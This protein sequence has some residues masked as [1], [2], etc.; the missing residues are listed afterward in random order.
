M[1]NKLGLFLLRFICAI[2]C[3]ILP[4]FH[5]LADTIEENRPI[6]SYFID[7]I[8]LRLI[9]QGGYYSLAIIFVLTIISMLNK[10]FREIILSIVLAIFGIMLTVFIY[11]AY[12]DFKFIPD[13]Y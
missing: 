12:L 8:V 11:E 10:K 7:N 2:T 4:I 3:S 9:V 5:C 1:I 13:T 6:I